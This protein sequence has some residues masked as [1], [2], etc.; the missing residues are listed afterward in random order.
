MIFG[1]ETPN[2]VQ[3]EE[4]RQKNKRLKLRTVCSKKIL[5]LFERRKR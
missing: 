4:A 3:L 2:G 1:G 5:T